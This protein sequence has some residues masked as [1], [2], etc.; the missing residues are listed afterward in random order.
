MKGK[1][2]PFLILPVFLFVFL[3]LNPFGINSTFASEDQVCPDE[4]DGWIK[5]EKDD[6]GQTDQLISY[7]HE[8]EGIVLE[9]CVKGG[10]DRIF[11][12]ENET[13]NSC[14]KVVGIGTKSSNVER[15]GSGSSCKDISH[16]SF[17]IGEAPL[18]EPDW[19]LI[20]T[21]V[22]QCV[23]IEGETYAQG[24][25]TITIQ[26]KGTGGGSIIN[27]VDELDIKVLEAYIKSISGNGEYDNG[28]IVW[29]FGEGL[30]FDPNSSQQYT[31]TILI[32][33]EAYGTY[34]NTAIAYAYP[35]EINNDLI[36]PA[37]V[38]DYKPVEVA[39][40]SVT[41]D[42]EC[43]IEEEEEE[44]EVE[45][46]EE[47]EEEENGDILGE[48]DEVKKEEIEEVGVVLAETGSGSN[49]FVYIIQ[50]LLSLSTILSGFFFSKKYIM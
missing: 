40:D 18:L 27:I 21:V 35:M 46:E 44:E 47:E 11:F 48:K 2:L 37:I 49:I 41:V 3:L 28:E 4:V 15:V 25:Y 30:N 29:D 16:A 22:E 43:E 20:K 12:S 6:P 32:P 39:R 13:W 33:E 45:E 1:Y 34:D 26:N 31:Y 50:S 14:W 9:V 8:G 42:L 19:A 38:N 36:L 10:Q 24:I 7:L 23:V 17:K 5:F